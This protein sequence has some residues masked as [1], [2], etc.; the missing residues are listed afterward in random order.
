M[1]KLINDLENMS[2]KD[3]KDNFEFLGEGIARK[4]FAIDEDTVLKVSKG[5]DGFYQNAVEYYV[6]SKASSLTKTIL[7][8]ILYYSPRYLIMKRAI[9]LT[10]FRRQNSIDVSKLDG[11]NWIN[12]PLYELKTKFFLFEEDLYHTDSW[13]IIGNKM[14]LIDYGCTS[15]FGDYFYTLIFKLKKFDVYPIKEV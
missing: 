8:P 7:C 12:T 4:V 2:R 9:P 3:I 14:V 6:F 10:K 13:G 11:L 1:E 5:E 15:S